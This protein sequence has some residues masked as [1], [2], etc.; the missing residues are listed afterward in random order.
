MLDT[1]ALYSPRQS[2]K[3]IELRLALSKTTM[4]LKAR[5]RKSL[6]TRSQSKLVPIV[7]D[8]EFFCHS[9]PLCN[10]HNRP[11]EA[12]TILASRLHKHNAQI[13][14]SATFFSAE[15]KSKFSQSATGPACYLNSSIGHCAS[16][17]YPECLPE[18]IDA[19]AMIVE[20]G[21]IHDGMENFL[22][23]KEEKYITRMAAESIV[24][25]G[26]EGKVL[27][28][29]ISENWLRPMELQVKDSPTSFEDSVSRRIVN[30]GTRYVHDNSFG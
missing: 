26:E 27:L 11:S 22:F 17:L 8:A 12:F 23:L 16:L 2:D 19:V 18:R 6:S 15:I 10:V 3:S 29:R 14:E 20:G 7:S 9:E 1:L 4:N 13:V 24:K 5:L 30:I 25:Y 28:D 21:A